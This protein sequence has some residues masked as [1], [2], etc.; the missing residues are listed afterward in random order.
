MRAG[1]AVDLTGW[2]LGLWDLGRRARKVSSIAIPAG[3]SFAAGGYFVIGQAAVPNVELHAGRWRVVG[4]HE[5]HFRIEEPR[6]ARR[7]M[8]LTR[9]QWIRFAA[10]SWRT[11]HRT[12]LDQMNAGRDGRPQCQRR[13]VGTIRVV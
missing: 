12:Q 8:L 1:H 3:T 5:R 13:L 7:S 10:L 6:M 4:Q 9:W 11:P 2:T